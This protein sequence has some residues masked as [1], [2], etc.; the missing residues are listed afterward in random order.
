M[1]LRQVFSVVLVLA[2]AHLGARGQSLSIHKDPN[3]KVILNVAPKAGWGFRV[4]Q[5][6]DWKDWRGVS[7]HLT[8]LTS[9]PI[10]HQKEKEIFYRLE[11]WE[12]PYDPIKVAVIG[13]STTGDFSHYGGQ[14]G[15]WGEGLGPYFG[16]DARVGIL[17]VPGQS[18][19][20][21]LESEWQIKNLVNL[22]PEFVFIQ[23]GMIDEL[24]GQAEKRTTI[25]EY[26]S[27]LTELVS[28]VREFGGSPVLIT[29]I[30]LRKFD[31]DG[32]VVPY[33]DERSDA[34]L[35]VADRMRCASVDLNRLTKNLYNDL[36]ENGSAHLTISD[37]LHL[38]APGADLISG[39]VVQNMPDF[40]KAY[41]MQ[42]Q[43]EP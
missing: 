43:S 6:S 22:S 18:S 13:D 7:D 21:Y 39:L 20:T 8:S 33:L 3:G 29:P 16:P 2:F 10:D 5:S 14:A 34:M 31:A 9:H 1:M 4:E 12:L 35:R 26:E 17:A 15:G 40:L 42:D 23:F 27:N 32:E 36:G 28:L 19:K 41:L 11:L 38:R 37:L 24:S 25:E 30:T